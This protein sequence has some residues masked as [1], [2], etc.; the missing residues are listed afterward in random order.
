[1]G[2]LEI[3]ILIETLASIPTARVLFVSRPQ[4]NVSRIV[5][6][7]IMKSISAAENITDIDGYVQESIEKSGKLAAPFQKEVVDPIE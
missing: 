2:T 7:W 5:P 6:K 4:V 1:M 3:E